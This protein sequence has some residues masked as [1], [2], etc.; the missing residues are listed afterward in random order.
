MSPLSTSL[1]SP[2]VYIIE[3]GIGELY[4]LMA[5]NTYYWLIT[6]GS[7]LVFEYLYFLLQASP[8]EQNVEKHFNMAVKEYQMSGVQTKVMALVAAAVQ[9]HGEDVEVLCPILVDVAKENQMLFLQPRNYWSRTHQQFPCKC[10]RMPRKSQYDSKIHYNQFTACS[11]V[12]QNSVIQ[13]YEVH[14]PEYNEDL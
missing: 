2:I 10:A 1:Q 5:S 12:S 6:A 9:E 3:H 7:I 8:D 4:H 13:M 11:M 14:K